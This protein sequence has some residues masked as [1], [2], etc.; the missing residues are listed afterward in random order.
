MEVRIQVLFF[1]VQYYV[2]ISTTPKELVY[3]IGS[4]GSLIDQKS[5]E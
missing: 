1:V 3:Y 2:V 4:E 5:P